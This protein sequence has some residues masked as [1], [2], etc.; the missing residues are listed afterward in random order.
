MQIVGANLPNA[1]KC[2]GVESARVTRAWFLGVAIVLAATSAFKVTAI[3]SEHRALGLP[4][5]VLFFLSARQT[6]FLAAVVELAVAVAV[7]RRKT[8]TGGATT[9]AWLS[10][11]FVTY[12][13]GLFT[14]TGGQECNC[15]GTISAWVGGGE[16]MWEYASMVLLA[17][18]ALPA[19]CI[20]ATNRVVDIRRT[21]FGVR[22]GILAVWSVAGVGHG[23]SNDTLG[24]YEVQGRAFWYRASRSGLI[25]PEPARSMSFWV[26][27][28]EHRWWVRLVRDD[29][30]QEYDPG[31][32]NGAYKAFVEDYEVA[33][34]DGA[35]SYLVK[36]TES[37]QRRLPRLGNA[38]EAWRMPGHYPVHASAD[39]VA[40]WSTYAAASYLRHRAD[41][42]VDFARQNQPTVPFGDRPAMSARWSL[43]PEPPGLLESLEVSFDT[44][45]LSGN[46]S[47]RVSVFSTNRALRVESTTNVNGLRL[48]YRTTVASFV[49]SP[50]A[51]GT[52]NTRMQGL[53]V[54]ESVSVTATP[55]LPG[56]IPPSLP[57]PV[58]L[59]EARPT[60]HGSWS[61]ILVRTNRWLSEAEVRRLLVPRVQRLGSAWP[62]AS[63]LAVLLMAPA[64]LL[65]YSRRKSNIVGQDQHET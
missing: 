43:M 10:C 8:N 38:G 14:T 37:V 52:F 1:D 30:G 17:Y 33:A 59:S 57:E 45:W 4:D 26:W 61:S 15:L 22:L 58:L 56:R 19:V 64:A 27:A 7:A 16:R 55:L 32:G 29:A 39:M 31:F 44:N 51:D 46:K 42:F 24:P 6:L 28:D 62:G 60:A 63:L 65:W 23:A 36:S 47:E 13:V 48:P 12:R 18:L 21:V 40:V 34:C 3:L 49:P 5:P 53:L 50:G 41:P 20:L 35:F 11:V 54:I 25:D 2:P 9:V